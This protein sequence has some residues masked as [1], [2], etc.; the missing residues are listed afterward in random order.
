MPDI[1]VVVPS[2][3]HEAFIERTLRSVFAQTLAPKEL[4]V[5]DD[6]SRDGSVGVIE[7]VLADSAVPARLIARENR[8]LCPTLNEGLAIAKGEFFAYLGSDDIWLPGFLERQAGLLAERPNAALAFAHAYVINEFDNIIDRTDNWTQF[9]D[10]DL[11]P[12]LLSGEIFS[13]PGVLYRRSAIDG[14]GWNPA[15]ALEDYEL[16]LALAA[17]GEFARNTEVLCAWRQHGGNTSSNTPAMLREQIAAQIR[18]RERLPVSP[19]DLERYQAR[20]LFRGAANCVRSGH[21]AAA[22]RLFL[23]N[24]SGAD[25]VGEVLRTSLM[26]LAPERLYRWQRARRHSRA[27]LRNGKLEIEDQLAGRR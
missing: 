27:A 13:S 10:G 15:A 23:A 3:D 18:L 7:R 1:S 6:G 26:L 22:F 17:N 25:S 12:T 14:I 21:R 5:I 20:L 16:Y 9:A 8:G 4:I 19:A 11:L 24:L 2:Y